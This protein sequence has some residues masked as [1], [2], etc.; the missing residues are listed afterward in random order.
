[1][2]TKLPALPALL[3]RAAAVPAVA[4]VGLLAGCFSGPVLP[5]IGFIYQQGHVP[6]DIAFD[7]TS[8]G[9]ATGTAESISI[10]GLVAIGDARIETAAQNGNLAVVQQV[11][12]ELFNVLGVYQRYTT[13]VHGLTTA[14]ALSQNTTSTESEVAGY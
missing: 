12:A 1:M 13:V 4:A 6:V 2:A 14:D 8:I 5:P 7:E 3:C 11:D 10:L 9:S